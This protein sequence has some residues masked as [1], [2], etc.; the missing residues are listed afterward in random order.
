MYSSPPPSSCSRPTPS[1]NI[2]RIVANSPSARSAN[3]HAVFP[4][5]EAVSALPE[6][7]RFRGVGAR[8]SV[9]LYII[10]AFVMLPDLRGRASVTASKERGGGGGG[11]ERVGYC[12]FVGNE[13]SSVRV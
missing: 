2:V 9:S 7:D 5:P 8:T 12:V 13:K 6:Q 3:V 10:Y 11:G 1:A 4:A